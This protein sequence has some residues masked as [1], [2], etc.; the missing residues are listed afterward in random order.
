MP[1]FGFSIIHTRTQ[2]ENVIIESDY[3]TNEMLIACYFRQQLF[4]AIFLLS[5]LY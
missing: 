4:M 3:Q 2:L 1:I 5:C